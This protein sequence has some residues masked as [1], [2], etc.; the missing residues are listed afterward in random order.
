MDPPVQ[1]LYIYLPSL[2]S[3]NPNSSTRSLVAISR[4]NGAGCHQVRRGQ[5]TLHLVGGV[6]L[7]AAASSPPCPHL[8]PI[9][10]TNTIF[11]PALVHV[12][13]C[14]TV[15]IVA[16]Q[17]GWPATRA[18]HA[19]PC[20]TFGTSWSEAS[21]K[22]PSST[23]SDSFRRAWTASGWRPRS[24]AASSSPTWPSPTS[25]PAP[26]KATCWPKSTGGTAT[27]AAPFATASS[28][29]VPSCS[30]RSTRSSNSGSY[31]I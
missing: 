14:L 18:Q 5:Q 21:G 6:P 19:S 20:R 7:R 22:M 9:V 15:W 10:S 16:V 30:P 27:M 23:S 3:K 4:R 17:A 26:R 25:S 11:R 12:L 24:S 28:G 1:R 29:S 13:A 31:C 8:P 2:R